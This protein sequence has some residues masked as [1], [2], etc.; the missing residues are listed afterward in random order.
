MENLMLLLATSLVVRL[1]P[2][3]TERNKFIGD[4]GCSSLV[5]SANARFR[6]SITESGDDLYFHEHEEAGHA[7]G[8]ICVQLNRDYGLHEA[9]ELLEHYMEALKGPFFILHQTGLKKETDWN[10]ESTRKVVDYWQ[11]SNQDE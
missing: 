8:V 4:T 9:T 5:F 3:K 2:N 10:A 1:A 11:D 7:Y 6:K